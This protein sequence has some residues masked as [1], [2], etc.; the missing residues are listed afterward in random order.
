MTATTY[1][2]RSANVQTDERPVSACQYVDD[3][4]GMLLTTQHSSCAPVQ[5]GDWV[6][7]T[8]DGELQVWTA[9]DFLEMF[10]QVTP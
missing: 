6:V 2:R 8:A 1:R 7:K 4:T 3:G 10:E 9:A 5:S